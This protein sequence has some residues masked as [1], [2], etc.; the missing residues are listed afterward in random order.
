M[1]FRTLILFISFGFSL[2]LAGLIY[3]YEKDVSIFFILLFSVFLISYILLNYLFEKFIYQR[4]KSV[5]KLIHNLKLGKDLKSALG[6]QKSDDPIADT[7]KAVRD[8][9]MQK[10]TEIEQLKAQEKFRKE[11]LSNISHEF[12]TPLFAIQ[13]YVETLRDGMIEENPT[14]ATS[15]LNRAARNLDRLS[16]LIHDLDEIAKL[17]SGEITLV[18]EKFDIQALIHETMDDLHYKAQ[19]SDITLIQVAKNNTP[20]FVV[21]DRKRIHQVLT[22]FI[23]NSIKYGK[24]GGETKI[25]THLLIDQIL[26]EITDNG[27]GIEEKNLPR[28]FERFFRTDKSRSRDV[29]GSGLGLA[30]VK[31]IIEAHQQNVHVR[32]TEGLGTSFSF[33]LERG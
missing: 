7:E 12:K 10:A 19:E 29:G 22:N 5:Y 17:E 9:S 16:F 15:F 8:W 20:V 6:N 31:H 25:K 32:S 3:Y 33:T 30:I 4:I 13:G 26:V 28:V 24:K 1:N 14:M 27:Q 21:A 11:F 23:E 2:I 18:K